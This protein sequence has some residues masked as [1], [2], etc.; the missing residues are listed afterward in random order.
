MT[1]L[2]NIQEFGAIE[3]ATF[4][5]KDGISEE[6]MLELIK[7]VDKEFLQKENGFLGHSTLKGKDNLY[8]DIAFATTQDKAEEI[9]SKWMKNDLALNYLEL[10]DESSVDMSFWTRI[11]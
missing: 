9:C 7:E 8:L 6:K 2:K 1:Q 3:I 10:I 4:R 11:K 5:L